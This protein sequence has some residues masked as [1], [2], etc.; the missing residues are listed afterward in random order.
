MN[1]VTIRERAAPV[2]GAGL[3]LLSLGARA[4]AA[5][6]PPEPPQP[7]KT[8]ME[9]VRAPASALLLPSEHADMDGF[10]GPCRLLDT[11][12]DPDN[13]FQRAGFGGL[14][15]PKAG[16]ASANTDAAPAVPEPASYALL[17]AG[18]GVVGI[19]ARRQAHRAPGLNAGMA[20]PKA[21]R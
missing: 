2:F 6:F 18:L 20:P 11:D 17:L 16:A 8:C 3:L 7:H 21:R 4:A 1:K 10:G 9:V 19:L 12:P 13:D 5:S 15:M 14:N